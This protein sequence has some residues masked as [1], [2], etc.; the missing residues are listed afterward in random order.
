[1][2]AWKAKVQ[3][4]AGKDRYMCRGSKM[5]EGLDVARKRKIRGIDWRFSR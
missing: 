1:M 3:R 4:N 2:E 5:D